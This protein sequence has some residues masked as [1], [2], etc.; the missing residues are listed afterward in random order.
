MDKDVVKSKTQCP[1]CFK[2][3]AYLD[4]HLSKSPECARGETKRKSER[5]Q[6]QV[7]PSCNMAFVELNMHLSKSLSCSADITTMTLPKDTPKVTP[8]KITNPYAKKPQGEFDYHLHS[9]STSHSDN[10]FS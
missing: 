3:F 8:L 2:S 5:R 9:F 10:S 7:C 4:M 6:D 1:I